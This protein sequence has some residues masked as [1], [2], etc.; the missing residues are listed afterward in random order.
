M[1]DPAVRSPI[2]P[3]EHLPTAAPHPPH[4]SPARRRFAQVFVVD[5][6]A[7]KNAFVLPGGKVFVFSGILPICANEDG[8]AS[9]LGHGAS[10]RLLVAKVPRPSTAA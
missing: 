9:V 7:T 6:P 5:D 1:R 3:S 4:R 8:L 10:N 2:R